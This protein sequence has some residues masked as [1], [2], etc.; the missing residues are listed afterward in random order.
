LQVPVGKPNIGKERNQPLRG[1]KERKELAKGPCGASG[2]GVA[3]G[4]KG[5]SSGDINEKGVCPQGFLVWAQK[6][7]ALIRREGGRKLTL[8][9]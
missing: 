6:N 3:L 2:N 1:G 7:R 9:F 4:G 8:L 5:D